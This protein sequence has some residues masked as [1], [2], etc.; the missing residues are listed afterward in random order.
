MYV[1]NVVKVIPGSFFCITAHC[2]IS[3]QQPASTDDATDDPVAT[4]VP[5][6]GFVTSA[7]TPP[8]AISGLIRPSFVY[9]LPDDATVVFKF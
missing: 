8:D 7:F 6:P 9:P 1:I 2:S 4:V 3:A 5:P